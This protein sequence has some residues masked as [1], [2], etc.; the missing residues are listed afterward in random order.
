M[1]KLLSKLFFAGAVASQPAMA[2]EDHFERTVGMHLLSNYGSEYTFLGASITQED[3]K[4]ELRKLDWPNGFY[5][6]VVISEP[7]I[8]MEVGGSLDPSDGLSARYLN[9]STKV[10]GVIITP[11][12][13]V[14][15]MEDILIKFA[16]SDES[17]KSD[18]D[19][20]FV[21]YE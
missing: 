4:R 21:T 18:Y 10:E 12:E 9:R 20:G 6:F 1:L 5:Q 8:S 13:S 14:E 16:D 3:I 7:G 15:E 19:F 2:E 11:P 17:W